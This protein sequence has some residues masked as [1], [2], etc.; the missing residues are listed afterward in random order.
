[1][2]NYRNHSNKGNRR[3]LTE[4]AQTRLYLPLKFYGP[5]P[6]SEEGDEG[7]PLL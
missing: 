4:N 6:D 3:K 1:M 2:D 7:G 5:R